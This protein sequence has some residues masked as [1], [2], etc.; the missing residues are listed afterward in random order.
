MTID[1]QYDVIIVGAGPAGLMAATWLSQAGVKTLVAEKQQCRTQAGHADGLE[2]RT[3]EILDSFGIGNAVWSESNPTVEVCLWIDS[4]DGIRRES[5]TL[6]HNPG[7]S[8]F[9]ECTLAQDRV[10]EHLLGFIKD[11]GNVKV[12]WGTVPTSIKI[13][14]NRVESIPHNPVEVRLKPWRSDIDQQC[15]GSEPVIESVFRTKY[16]VGCDGA[17]S[18]VRKHFGLSLQGE[19]SNEHW[20]VIDC[21]PVTDFPD[22]RKRCIIKSRVGNIMII[23]RERRLVRFYIQLSPTVAAKIRSCYHHAALIV[24]AKAILQP[25][26]FDAAKVQ[27]STIYTVGQRLC[28]IYSVQNRVFLAGDAVHTH[29]PKAGQGM[30][31]SMQDTYNLGWKLASVLKG[32]ATP[33]LLH[34]YQSERLPVGERL[35]SFD[36]QIC[37]GIC[38]SAEA[39][40]ALTSRGEINPLKASLRE[41]NSN[42]SGLGVIYDPGIL[43]AASGHWKLALKTECTRPMSKPY[44]AEGIIVGGRFP[45]YR[46]LC[47]SDSR[48]WHLQQRL[49]STGQW[50]LVVFGGNIVESAQML[51]VE[52]LAASLSQP[53]SF[54]TKIN[55]SI[56]QTAVGSIAAH[57]VHSSCHRKIEFME[58]PE[59]F[60]PFDPHGG[61]EYGQVF[62]DDD[63]YG[64]GC[65]HAYQSYG[66]AP[67]GCLVLIRPDQHVAFVGDLEDTAALE[68]YFAG[69]SVPLM[70]QAF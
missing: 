18:W 5:M 20:G 46:V 3:I 37:R 68:A 51:R 35:V 67:Q 64:E 52:R 12:K 41:E 63:A 57:L 29:S 34:T 15:K 44:L 62:A 50:N 16:V 69:F 36:K 27:W 53:D 48:P 32:M 60:R 10:E 38:S 58:L 31:V 39:D 24:V 59:I 9:K 30:N 56:R 6:N 49:R 11:H 23:P 28:P 8:R 22:I 7:L 61:Y 26:F 25:Y 43:V 42:A 47:Q 14:E 54:F 66:I 17:R 45:S 70:N 21:I 4:H 33:K 2:S 1:N 19:S 40:K 55:Q 13:D 65:G